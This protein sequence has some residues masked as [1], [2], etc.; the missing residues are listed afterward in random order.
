LY[1]GHLDILPAGNVYLGTYREDFDTARA[2]IDEHY[3]E[4]A[5]RLEAAPHRDLLS[6]NICQGIDD[7]IRP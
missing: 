1:L 4:L 7:L 5:G 3:P 6:A 2:Y